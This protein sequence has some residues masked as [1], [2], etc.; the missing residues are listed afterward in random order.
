MRNIVISLLAVLMVAMFF[1][2]V[3][4]PEQVGADYYY[5]YYFAS[6]LE[7]WTAGQSAEGG[8]GETL[9]V[10][11]ESNGNGHALLSDSG[12]GAAWMLASFGG[13]EGRIRVKFEARNVEGCERC[14]PLL[15]IGNSKPASLEQFRSVGSALGSSWQMYVLDLPAKAETVMVAIGYKGDHA[16]SIGVDSI[17]V[18]RYSR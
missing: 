16:G 1:A 2:S 14:E 8:P 4:R 9:E 18:K 13:R 7:P 5:N 15:Y 12:A 17:S 3:A 11:T 10:A 6:G